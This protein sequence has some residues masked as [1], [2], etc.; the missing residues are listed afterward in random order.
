MSPEKE[1]QAASGPGDSQLLKTLAG[2]F[3]NGMGPG[4]SDMSTL[5][6][7]HLRV[8]FHSKKLE[9]GQIVAMNRN[10]I[11]RRDTVTRIANHSMKICHTNAFPSSSKRS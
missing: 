8:L 3:A 10:T 11:L 6:L 2:H 4:V 1:S 5:P 7:S 9:Q